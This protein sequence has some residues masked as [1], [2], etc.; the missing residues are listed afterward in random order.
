MTHISHEQVC[1][2]YGLRA[3]SELLY[4]QESLASGQS[5]TRAQIAS[6]LGVSVSTI[7]RTQSK[8]KDF[9]IALK[10]ERYCIVINPLNHDTKD[11]ALS[12]QK[13]VISDTLPQCVKSDTPKS[14]RA[15]KAPQTRASLLECVESD[16]QAETAH[17]PSQ[18]LP[19]ECVND[20]FSQSK[21]SIQGTFCATKPA[22]S[23][24]ESAK[25]PHS[26]YYLESRISCT[27]SGDSK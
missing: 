18:N 2:D 10:E 25:N 26:M 19:P 20:T 1:R 22:N 7:A 17:K 9:I 5:P 14:Q 23:E 16:T 13:C 11:S 3:A 12:K 8:A 24:Q 15:A 6:S 4:M 27:C 21:E